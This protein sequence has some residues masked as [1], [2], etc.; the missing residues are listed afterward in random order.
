MATIPV[1]VDQELDGAASLE[2]ALI[3]NM[4]RE[5][6]SPIEEARTI[7]TLLDDLKITATALCQ[8]AWT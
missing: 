3:E 6:L 5:D 1:L 7:A 8:A 4:A 2:V